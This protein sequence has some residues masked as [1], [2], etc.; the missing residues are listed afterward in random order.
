MS[1]PLWGKICQPLGISF[2]VCI[3]MRTRAIWMC[4]Q[5]WIVARFKKER[6]RRTDATQ[7]WGGF[8][9]PK[10]KRLFEAT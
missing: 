5:P 6:G 7:A 8:P 1:P 10:T 2:G 3:S 4:R 9:P